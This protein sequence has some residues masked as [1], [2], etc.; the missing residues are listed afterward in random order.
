MPFLTLLR[1]EQRG[2]DLLA[3]VAPSGP[4]Y[5]FENNLALFNSLVYHA[6]S[7]ISITSPYFVPDPSLL[8]LHMRNGLVAREDV[9]AVPG[10]D[11]E[12]VVQAVG[13]DPAELA[14]RTA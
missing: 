6:T 13:L 5:E 10:H 8:G 12:P 1:P 3:Q 4:A 2:G 11:W 14:R 9:H 7:R